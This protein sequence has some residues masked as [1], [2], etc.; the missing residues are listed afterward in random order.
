MI[1]NHQHFRTKLDQFIAR[2]PELFPVN[3]DQGYQ[4]YGMARPSVKMPDIKR[5]RIRLNA[6]DEQRHHPIYTVVPSFVLPYMTGTTDEVENALFL[7]RFGVPFWAL[8]H[9][10]GHN[11]MYWQ[12]LVAQFGG[13]DIVGMTLKDPE[14]L[15][16]HLL[17]DEKHTRLNGEKA[18]IATTVAQDCVLGISRSNGFCGSELMRHN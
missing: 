3:I 13:N 14:L 17:A 2:Y 1:N 8:T 9:V 7:R 18:Y 10:F 5:Q 15:P 11:D 12:R 4:L 6:A 16:D